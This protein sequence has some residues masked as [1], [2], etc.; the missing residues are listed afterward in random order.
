MVGW[1]A[2]LDQMALRNSI[3]VYTEL[4]RGR[5]TEKRYE[6][7]KNKYL[8]NPCL[9]LCTQCSLCPPTCTTPQQ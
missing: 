6:R 7:G 4:S 8:N 2:V 1:F 5:E 3:S 9:P